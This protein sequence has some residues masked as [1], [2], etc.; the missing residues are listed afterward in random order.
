MTH[1]VDLMWRLADRVALLKGGR[2]VFY[3][4]KNEVTEPALR[5]LYATGEN[6][7]E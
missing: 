5:D 6:N 3:G 7:G 2:V 4:K 1:D